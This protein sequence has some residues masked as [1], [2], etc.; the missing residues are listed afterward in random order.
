VQTDICTFMMASRRI[1]LRMR[2]FQTKFAEKIKTRISC[3][4]TPLPPPE[5]RA[6]YEI[7]WENMVQPDRP[8]MTI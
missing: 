2:F 3:P 7:M 8:Q 6:V 4:V 5:N 1:I